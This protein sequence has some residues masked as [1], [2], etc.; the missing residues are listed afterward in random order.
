MSLQFSTARRGLLC[1][2]HTKEGG[3]IS[4]LGPDQ[5][6]VWLRPDPKIWTRPAMRQALAGMD[7]GAVYRILQAQGF[8]QQRIAALTGQSQPEVSAILRGR[9]VIAY[10]VLARIADGLGIPPSYLGL[11]CLDCP[12]ITTPAAA[13]KPGR[14]APPQTGT[15]RPR[16]RGRWWR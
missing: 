15:V 9:R 14:G 13:A 4:M 6:E 12:H 7:I 1:G 5:G 8:S 11:A 3:T 10:L 16:R 2:S